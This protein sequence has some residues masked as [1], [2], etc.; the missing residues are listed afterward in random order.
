[1]PLSRAF[2]RLVEGGLIAPL[3]PRPPPHPTLPGF[4]TDLHCAYHQR[5]GPDTDSCAMLRHAIQD[6]IDQGLVDLRCLTMTTDPLP[7]HDTRAIPPPTSGVHLVEFSGD[8]IFMMGWDG[9]AHPQSINLYTNSDFSGYTSSQQIPRPFRL[10][11]YEVPR[12][13]SISPVYL[14]HVLPMTPFILI[15]EEYGHVHRDV[16]IVT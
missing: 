4:K 16:Q 14:Q 13:T 15:P 2:Q 9:E 1:M 3:P 11:P 7:T 5:A 12:H 6:L 10:I 8:K